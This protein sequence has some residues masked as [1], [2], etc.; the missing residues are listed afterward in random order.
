MIKLFCSLHI[1][2]ILALIS[3]GFLV[4]NQSFGYEVT[5]LASYQQKYPNTIAVILQHKQTIS[6]E[7]DPKTGELLIYE[8]NF[9]EIL[10]LKE[11]SKFY[12]DQ[13]IYLSEFFEDLIELN[14]TVY[15]DLGK[16]NV[17]DSDDFKTFDSPPSS[18]V[19]HDDD[20]EVVFDLQK[21]GAGYRT[22]VSYK[23]RIKRPEFFDL[24]HFAS[25]YPCEL[26]S[27]DI[28]YPTAVKLKFYERNLDKSSVER[29]T[30]PMKKNLQ[31]SSWVIKGLKEIKSEEGSTVISN[32]I[33]HLIAQICSYNYNGKEENVI[34]TPTELHAF[35]Q[36]LLL[37]K[38]VVDKKKDPT[39]GGMTVIVDSIT[40][41][42]TTDLQKIDTIFNWVQSNIKYIAFEDGINGY[43]PR[44]S[45]MVM[46]NRFG[47]CKDMGNLLVEML[48]HAGV[49][50]AHVAWVGTRDIPYLM[51]EIPSPLTC[52]HVICVVD[53]PGGGYYYLDA[54]DSEGT[55]D[56]PPSAIQSK[57]LL[58]HEGLDKFVIH[59]VP[60]IAPEDN[61][62]KTH[63]KYRLDEDDSIRGTGI[64]YYFG[65]ERS[66]LTYNLQNLNDDDLEEYVKDLALGGYNR[67]TLG[68]YSIEN[69]KNKSKELVLKYDFSVD[70]FLIQNDDELIV[71]PMLFKPRITK[72]NL[73]DH[74]LTRYKEYARKV[75]YLYEFEIPKGYSIKHLPEDVELNHNKFNFKGTFEVV[76]NVIVVT[77]QY[78]YQ[79]LEIP[80]DLYE[81]WNEFSDV[82]TS[83]TIENII[84]QKK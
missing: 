5:E 61:F 60:M 45:N 12:T 19:F 50:G 51:S 82:L 80:T 46:T 37:Q 72:Y 71:N 21:L 32:H 25:Y 38:E 74:S 2:K 53:R 39:N 48:N 43:V 65:Y 22:I 42:M 30:I 41:G 81:D 78:D 11:E 84:L 29:A 18:W 23:K 67:Y 66:D 70:N 35:F 6:I 14:V 52:N 13:N 47:D 76:D 24:F 10:Y 57:E 62:F 79:L 73:E 33:P 54:T 69:L 9:E 44:P 34:S 26:S 31:K 1:S 68:E 28:T 59:S 58:I 20:K 64:D 17:L 63:L 36:D 77:L 49:P 3:I 16:K 55:F 75:M 40:K 15:N 7:I 56:L 8:T 27:V 83:F 4:S